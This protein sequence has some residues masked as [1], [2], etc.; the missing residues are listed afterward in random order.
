MEKG[1]LLVKGFPLELRKR[2]KMQALR[3]DISLKDLVI[4]AIKEYLEKVGG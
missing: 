1:V 2:A 3:E 4:R